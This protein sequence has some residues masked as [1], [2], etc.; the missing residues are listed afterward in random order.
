MCNYLVQLLMVAVYLLW[1]AVALIEDPTNIFFHHEMMRGHLFKC[2]QNGEGTGP[3]QLREKSY[4][5]NIML[6]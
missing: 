3:L 2:Y 5:S 4:Y 1:P 6:L